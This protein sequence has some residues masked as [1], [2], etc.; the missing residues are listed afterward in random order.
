L[1]KVDKILDLGILLDKKLTLKFHCD[2]I[3]SKAK[4]L[5]GFVK[6]RAKEFDNVV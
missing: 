6:R 4:G 2:M 3:I 5:L 1:E